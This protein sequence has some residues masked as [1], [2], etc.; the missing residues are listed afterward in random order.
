V[1]GVSS[2]TTIIGHHGGFDY[3]RIVQPVLDQ[4]CVKCHNPIDAPKQIDLTGGKTDFFNVSYECLA[5]ENQGGR[6]SPYVNWIPSYNG[7][8]W[9]ILETR[10]KTWGSPASKLAEVIL[11]GHPD[12]D[13]KPQVQ[14]DETSRRRILSWIDLNVPYYGTSE[15]AY[16]E[17]PGCRQIFPDNLKKVLSDVAARRCVECHKEVKS[18]P[19]D[20]LFR[21]WVRITEPELNP[22]LVAPLAKSA[23]GSQ[24]CSKPVFQSKEDPDYQAILATFKP[25]HEMLARRPR[26]D[27]PGGQ[28]AAEVC[29]TCQ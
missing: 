24:K 16:P 7:Q 9:N 12:K 20:W 25:I 5:R 2:R 28:P 21:E 23:G 18:A 26:M 13:G 4:H 14:M 11:S 22:F 3:S 19:R 27:M 10:P 8:E 17:R 6:G 15:T 1:A 29:R